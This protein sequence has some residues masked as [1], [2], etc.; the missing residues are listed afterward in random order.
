M[1]AILN[2]DVIQRYTEILNILLAYVAP[3][4]KLTAIIFGT[5]YGINLLMDI[6]WIVHQIRKN[7]E[8]YLNS[9]DDE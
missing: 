3:F 4:A 2:P 9:K 7:A 6:A 8:N 5:I 1:I